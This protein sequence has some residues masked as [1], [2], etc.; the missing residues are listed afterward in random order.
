MQQ[1][2]CSAV[3]EENCD[4]L[5]LGD[6]PHPAPTLLT[7]EPLQSSDVAAE[8]TVGFGELNLKL[9]TRVMG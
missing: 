1:A 2:S 8:L 4:S 5:T 3:P 9:H 6:R 7:D